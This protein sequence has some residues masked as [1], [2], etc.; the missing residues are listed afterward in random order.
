[1]CG[2]CS[3][4]Q[5]KCLFLDE[6][7]YWLSQWCYAWSYFSS[8]ACF[9]GTQHIQENPQATKYRWLKIW[10]VDEL[11]R[12][13]LPFQLVKSSVRMSLQDDCQLG[14][15]ALFSINMKHDSTVL[16]TEG[17]FRWCFSFLWSDGFATVN[18]VSINYIL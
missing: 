18:F 2:C 9:T 15:L 14:A 10:K 7:G 13:C 1:M 4:N 5:W 16:N 3:Q 8:Y 17:L 12:S 11:N 6:Y